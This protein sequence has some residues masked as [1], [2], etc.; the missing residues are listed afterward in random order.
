MNFLNSLYA[1]IAITFLGFITVLGFTSL[2]VFQSMS[3][4]YSQ[5]V[6][7]RLNQS[8]AMYVNDQQLLINQGK[9]NES[10]FDAITNIF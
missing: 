3:E 6:M 1:K 2:W 4:M 8:V 9:V 7:Q 5:E 10:E